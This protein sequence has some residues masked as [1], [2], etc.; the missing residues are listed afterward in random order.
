MARCARLYALWE[1]YNQDP[2]FL[3]G[4]K[5]RAELAL[6]S[7][8]NGNYEAGIQELEKMLQ[9]GGISLALPRPLI[10]PNNTIYDSAVLRCVAV[11][12]RACDDHFTRSRLPYYLRWVL[13][14]RGPS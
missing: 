10:A 8:R 4:Q 3:Y 11:R 14:R 7:C 13:Q 9:R 2:V 12:L 1:R 6:Y 5:A